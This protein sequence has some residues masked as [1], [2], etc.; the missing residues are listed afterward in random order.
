[1]VRS[2]GMHEDFDRK[3]ELKAGSKRAFGLV[4]AV[5]FTVIGFWPLVGGGP[6]RFWALAVAFLFALAAVV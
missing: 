4:F 3:N 1:M 6:V 5:V 2:Q